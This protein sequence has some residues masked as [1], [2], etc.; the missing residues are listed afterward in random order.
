MKNEI[1]IVSRNK[2][3]MERINVKIGIKKK[4]TMTIKITF[5]P[6]CGILDLHQTRM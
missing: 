2:R 3:I 1:H 6:S 4:D 5:N